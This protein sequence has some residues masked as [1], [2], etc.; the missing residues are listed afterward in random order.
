MSSIST[1]RFDETKAQIEKL[2][3]AKTETNDF[4]ARKISVIEKLKTIESGKRIAIP[5][6][7]IDLSKNKRLEEIDD[8]DPEFL[9]LVETIREVGILQAPVVSI[10]ENEIVPLLGHRRIA[11]AKFINAKFSNMPTVNCEIKIFPE[12]KQNLLASLVENTARKNWDI[13]AVSKSLKELSELGY[14][15][16]RLAELLSKDRNT[17]GR[18][19][20]VASWDDECHKIIKDYPEQVKIQNI[21]YIASK[22]LTLSE[23]LSS[24]KTLAGL[25]ENEENK[26]EINEK[27]KKEIN[28]SKFSRNHTKAL[29]YIKQKNLSE[30]E[31]KIVFEVLNHFGFTRDAI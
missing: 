14:S 23:V 29:E 26:Q 30:S 22:S 18:L 9:Q 25:L 4:E 13:I 3:K 5:V 31:S 1:A 28:L 19:I 12:G 15:I 16:T 27:N 6:D 7:L 24:L 11:A 10:I 8:N 21:L 20:K 17:I 2:N